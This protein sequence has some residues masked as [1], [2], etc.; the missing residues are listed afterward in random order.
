MGCCNY[1]PFS[2]P[3][4]YNGYYYYPKVIRNISGEII[5]FE[6]LLKSEIANT[7]ELDTYKKNNLTIVENSPDEIINF[8]YECKNRIEK[9]YIE[10]PIELELRRRYDKLRLE[11]DFYYPGGSKIS[12]YFLKKY[13]EFY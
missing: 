11:S 7:Y 2:K 5:K 3:A 13:K 4:D 1:L 9:N 12:G 8:Y 10:D 6:D